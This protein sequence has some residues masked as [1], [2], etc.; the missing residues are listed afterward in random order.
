M[1]THKVIWQTAE[2]VLEASHYG[3]SAALI[4]TGLAVK[5][6]RAGEDEEHTRNTLVE[7]ELDPRV[8][9]LA[10]ARGTDTVRADTSTLAGV[11]Q[12]GRAQLVDALRKNCL[13]IPP[14]LQ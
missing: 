14:Y 10:Q 6:K 3:H 2:H 13:V 8:E 4:L 1:A 7:V 5:F 11:L 12:L 9:I